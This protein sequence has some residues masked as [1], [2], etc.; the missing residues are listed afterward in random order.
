[1]GVIKKG[2]FKFHDEYWSDI[3]KDARDLIKKMLTLDQD[4]RPTAAELLK[5]KWIGLSEAELRKINLGG[6]KD[7]LQ[8]FNAKR[9]LKAAAKTVMAVNKMQKAVMAFK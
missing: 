1:M 7:R 2:K 6:A 5:H 3:S 4:K 8:E 9:K